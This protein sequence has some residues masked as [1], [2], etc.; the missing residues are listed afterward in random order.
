MIVAQR[1][2]TGLAALALLGVLPAGRAEAAQTTIQASANVVKSLTF[3]AKQNLDFGTL[4]LP[5]APGTYTVSISMTGALTCPAGFVCSGTPRP[6]I[7]NVTGS[8]GNIIAITAVA[9]DLVNSSNG[10]RL[11]FT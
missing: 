4:M 11:R 10:S 8:N 3:V 6:A 2:T 9:S 5:S 1:I 7:F